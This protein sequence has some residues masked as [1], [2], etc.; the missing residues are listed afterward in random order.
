MA[1]QHKIINGLYG[2]DHIAVRL[3]SLKTGI[4][5]YNKLFNKL[6]PDRT[7]SVPDMGMEMAFYDLPNGGYVEIIAPTKEDSILTPALKKNGPGMNLMAFQVE[8]LKATVEK[9]KSNGVRIVTNGLGQQ[10]VHPK[11]SHGLLIQLVEKPENAKRRNKVGQVPDTSGK[12][13]AIVSYK[14]TVIFVEDLEMAIESYTKLGLK[15][16][17]KAPPN[18]AMG[19]TQALFFLRGGGMIELIGPTPNGGQA[20][21]NF[22]KTVQ[23]QGE[24]FYLLSLDGTAGIVDALHERGIRTRETDLQHSDIHKSATLTPKMLFQL[25]PVLMGAEGEVVLKKKGSSKM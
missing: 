17:F 20:S 16:T 23:S 3:E 14:C 22:L 2:F 7:G 25:N 13:A 11:S 24:G 4:P 10:L 8:D 5:A 6:S 9:M 19:F 21:E 12:D 15:L 18:E 1:H